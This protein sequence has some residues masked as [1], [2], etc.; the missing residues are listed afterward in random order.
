MPDPTLS[1]PRDVIEPIIH[2]VDANKMVERATVCE[3]GRLARSC[4]VCILT[5]DIAER[6]AE[7]A[8]LTAEVDRLSKAHKSNED[9]LMQIALYLGGD[10]REALVSDR[11]IAGLVRFR[12]ADALQRAE[13]AEAALKSK[14]DALAG[15]V[16]ARL[17]LL[18]HAE[19]WVEEN[20]ALRER[21]AKLE[22]LE[23]AVKR[24]QAV[25]VSRDVAQA[26]AALERKA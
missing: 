23:E 18:G 15:E 25:Y 14:S 24:S 21:I 6:D 4:D 8:R 1:I 3:H 11:S 17:E 2:I 9:Q 22:A 10:A 5:A 16:N 13:A 26:L 19:R 20:D 7:I 12:H